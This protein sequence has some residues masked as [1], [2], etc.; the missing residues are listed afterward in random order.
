MAGH[1]LMWSGSLCSELENHCINK[2]VKHR[3]VFEH[4][5]L[6]AL[7]PNVILTVCLMVKAVPFQFASAGIMYR[8]LKKV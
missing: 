2:V 4:D 8:F 6:R 3:L 1:T 7:L 5:H